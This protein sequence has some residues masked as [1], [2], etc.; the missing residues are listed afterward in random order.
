MLEYGNIEEDWEKAVG[1]GGA[2][3]L[4]LWKPEMIAQGLKRF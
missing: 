4:A 2:R 1:G 3:G